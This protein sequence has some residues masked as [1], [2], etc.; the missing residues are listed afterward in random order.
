M[1][2]TLGLLLCNVVQNLEKDNTHRDFM[3]LCYIDL[4]YI[5][6]DLRSTL[7][8]KCC[9]IRQ[10]SGLLL[11]STFTPNSSISYKTALAL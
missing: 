1:A 4:I 7:V 9:C 6:A 11:V 10:S 8:I 2:S 3:K 5:C